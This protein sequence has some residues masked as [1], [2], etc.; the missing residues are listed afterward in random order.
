MSSTSPQIPRCEAR[1]QALRALA[2]G[3][4]TLV[5]GACGALSRPSPVKRMYLLEPTMPAAVA[6]PK[7]SSARVGVVSVAAPFRGKT[8]VFRQTDLKY[9][10]DYYDEFFVAPA[11]MFSES[12]AKALATANVFRRVV[13]YG[14]ASDDGDYVLDGFVSEMYG[15]ARNTAAPAAVLTI[16]YYLSP[17]N[18][19]AP[20]VVWSKEYRQ[21]ATMTGTDSDALAKGLNTAF[22]TILAELTRDLAAAQLPAQ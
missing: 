10:A 7:P 11:I 20:G 6:T 5:L 16:A 12:T 17:A 2:S 4:A 14:G 3:A 8:F 19:I 18:V 15:D 21:R 9:E 22:S 13:P 1:R